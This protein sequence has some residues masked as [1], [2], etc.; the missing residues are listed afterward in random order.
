MF[1]TS[2]SNRMRSAIRLGTP[3]STLIPLLNPD[4]S[5]VNL[6]L[7][8]AGGSAGLMNGAQ[9]FSANRWVIVGRGPWANRSSANTQTG[10]I[11]IAT[12]IGTNANAFGGTPFFSSGVN[13]YPMG[14]MAMLAQYVGSVFTPVASLTTANST[15]Q[16]FTL[17]A[18]CRIPPGLLFAGASI[19]VRAV[20]RRASVGSNPVAANGIVWLNGQDGAITGEIMK[21][22]LIGAAAGASG[23]IEDD[24][25]IHSGGYTAYP[26]VAN[27]PL[28]I[29]NEQFVYV[30]TS[31][32]FE[33]GAT[34]QLIA[35]QVILRA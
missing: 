16:I 29:A 31:A 24:A 12:D 22:S 23:I 30:G 10:N 9:A 2:L 17:P 21:S 14:G 28:T 26:A 18:P 3:T 25:D 15:A 1:L 7:A 5:V 33:N 20:I 32:L 13:W 27:R 34:L 19:H 8:T 4:G 11:Y 6:P 35:L